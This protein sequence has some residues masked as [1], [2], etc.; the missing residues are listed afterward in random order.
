MN[1]LLNNFIDIKYEE[2][3]NSSDSNPSPSLSNDSLILITLLLS[4]LVIVICVKVCKM[5]QKYEYI[6]NKVDN[7]ITN[8]TEQPKDH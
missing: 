4:I 2:D 3:V 7:Y 1:E 6:Q 8:D 5:D